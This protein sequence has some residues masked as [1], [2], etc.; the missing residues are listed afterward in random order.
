MASTSWNGSSSDDFYDPANWSNGDL[1][2]SHTCQDAHI[3][4]TSESDRAVAVANGQSYGQIH[5]LSIDDYGTLKITAAPTSAEGGNVF[6]VYALEIQPE[7]QLI[8]D[9]SAQVELGL[10]TENRGGTISIL[11]NPGNVILD[12]N[13]LNGSGT[14]NLVNSTLGSEAAPIHIPDMDITLQNGSTLYTAW[15]AVGKSITFDPATS[16]TVVL[17]GSDSQ[18]TTPI[19]GVSENAHF[20]INGLGQNVPSSA[21]YVSNGDGTYSLVISFQNRSPLTLADIVPADGF[22]PTGTASI[23]KDAAGDWVISDANAASTNPDYT[24]TSTHQQLQQAASYAADLNSDSTAT[25]TGFTNHS[26]VATDH[27]TATGTADNPAAW[28]D[29]SNWSLGTEPQ[30]DSCYHAAFDGTAS[31]PI[32]AIVTQPNP[33]QFVSL[34]VNSDATL[35][36]AAPAGQNPNSYVFSTA[37]FEVRGNGV[38]NIDT[39]AKV[40]LGGV[41]VVDGTLNIK[42]NDGNVILDNGQLNGGG[43]LN[44]ID[45]TFGSPDHPISAGIANINLE[46]GS[47]YYASLYGL[48]NTVTFDDSDNVVV[49]SGNTDNIGVQFEN[50]NANSH[51]AINGDKNSKPTAAVYTKNEDGSYTLNITLDNGQTITLA[52][53]HTADG[54]VPGSSSFTQDAAGDWVINTNGSDV[55]FVEGTLIRTTRGDVAVEDLSVGDEVVVL[56]ADEASR[57]I[58]WIGFNDA[59]VKANLSDSEAGYPVRILKDAIAENVPSRDLLVTAEHCLFLEGGF[60]PVRMLVNGSSIFYDKSL[61]SY[62]YFHIETEQHS[63]LLAEN[64]PSESYLDTG[65]R[66]S[67]V[68]GRVVT[69]ASRH[70]SW[71]SDA[72]A[73]LTTQREVVEGL[74]KQIA[75]RAAQALGLTLPARGALTR[76]PELVFQTLSGTT[77]RRLSDVNGVV[78]VEVPEGVTQVR[79]SSRTS[80]PSD[81][82]GPFVDDRRELGVLIA[83]VTLQD[84]AHRR[85]VTSHLDGTANVGWHAME[86]GAAARWTNGYAVLDLGDRVSGTKGLLKIRIAAAGPY[87]VMTSEDQ[88]RI[89]A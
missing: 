73:P 7:G 63:V 68:G 57:R 31:N 55:C 54:Y 36:I 24:A 51:F 13:S 62:R 38:L 44:L 89:C 65:N 17:D 58:V 30:S 1:P 20:A 26:A 74:H 27:F 6:A 2:Q 86:S 16:N 61:T 22:V 11:N 52:H 82:I 35:T 71:A 12:G 60:V 39:A 14:L 53:I 29:A 15:N 72:A 23:V 10:Y 78:T 40:E 66:R 43:T 25:T 4:G 33:A 69:L 64:A 70:L 18:I 34:S 50:V 88:V 67:F 87:R 47:T 5:S 21:S 83:D 77:L 28:E 80:S 85:A 48:R 75:S 45:S 46:D 49:L 41:N 8:I 59:S 37:G 32:Y 76:K 79:I 42:G 9:T 56:E 19:Y 81:I 84:G 3:G